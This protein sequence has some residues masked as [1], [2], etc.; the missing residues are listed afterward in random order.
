MTIDPVRLGAKRSLALVAALCVAL[1]AL[2]PTSSSYEAERFVSL[3]VQGVTGS[4][5]ARA[6]VESVGGE[7]TR[8]LPIVRGVAAKVPAGSVAAL[9]ND[10]RIL[11]VTE[12]ARVGFEADDFTLSPGRIGN[13]TNSSRLVKEGVTGQGVTVALLDTGVYDHPDLAGRVVHCED[14]SAENGTEAHCADTFGHGTFMAGL[15]GGNGS[16]S[17]GAF[18]GSAPGVNI[19]S[20]KMAGFDGAS[21]VSNILAGIQ[22]VVAHRAQF[23]IKAL[24]LSLGSDSSQSHALSPLN[25][26]VQR[27][28]RSGITVVV[29]AGNS[30]PG[31]RT[32]LKPAD[33]PY[34]ITVGASNDESTLA[35]N[36][37]RI[38]VF[39]SRGPTRTDGLAKP[40]VVAPGV[41]TVSLRSPG[42]AIDQKFGDSAVVRHHYFR[43]TGTSMSAATV[44]GIVAQI[45]QANPT[46]TP[47]Q[48]KHRLMSTAR[49]IADTDPYAAGKGLVDAYAAA[50]STSTQKANQY[51]LLGQS[52]GLGSI[53]GARGNLDIDV[54][55][56]YGVS[57]FDGEYIAKYEEAS[58]SVG[59][60]LGLVPYSGTVYTLT[61]WDPT[62]W[63]GVSW[64]DGEWAGV[65]WK[66]VSWKQTTWDGVSWKGVSW[67]NADWEG[68]SWKNVNWDGVSW[69]A[70][71]FQSAWYAAAWD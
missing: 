3:I 10:R 1:M 14:F 20:L 28:W 53:D 44:T 39:S 13:I 59:N 43:G 41:H 19:V 9:G 51:V 63:E 27:A 18:A 24:N 12:N 2:A 21:D 62:S 66:G 58:R 57:L 6:A 29:S 8:N 46:L 52:T 11:Q 60:I 65:S 32:I 40:D 69:K 49:R 42:S 26:A 17:G 38:P 50:R 47:D 55:T 34:V 16:V 23:N 61:G 37:D 45:L 22:W 5:D 31:S 56:P 64:K 68:V 33:D 70:T 15:I 25:Y 30:G 4:G 35:I 67:K 54:T 71:T 36:D 7:V 48:V